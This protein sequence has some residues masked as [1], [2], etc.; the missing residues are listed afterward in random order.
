MLTVKILVIQ[1][2]NGLGG[3]RAEFPIDARLFV[4]RGLEPGLS[5]GMGD[6]TLVRRFRERLIRADTPDGLAGWTTLPLDGAGGREEALNGIASPADFHELS[7]SLSMHS[8]PER[9][10]RGPK[11][12]VAYPGF[13]VAVASAPVGG[14]GRATGR[15]DPPGSPPR[16]G[17]RLPSR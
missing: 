7:S 9:C 4:P 17:L 12:H 3:D 6:V 1:A 15:P 14:S 16:T 5:D 13:A 10:R 11:V 8:G 2:R